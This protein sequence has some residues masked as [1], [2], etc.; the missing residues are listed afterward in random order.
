MWWSYSLFKA[1]IINS[2]HITGN[3]ISLDISFF[4]HEVNIYGYFLLP[5]V[6]LLLSEVSRVSSDW[7]AVDGVGGTLHGPRLGNSTTCRALASNQRSVF[8][9]DVSW[10]TIC[11][12]FVF[13]ACLLLLKVKH[14][15]YF[16]KKQQLKNPIKRVIQKAKK[17]HR[18]FIA[19]NFEIFVVEYHYF[20]IFLIL[21]CYV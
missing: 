2:Y 14:K 16:K 19:L 10:R 6:P 18:Q 8:L 12:T 21:G 5:W 4:K 13:L 15:T 17:K 1:A 3:V 9:S 20:P 7:R 11:C